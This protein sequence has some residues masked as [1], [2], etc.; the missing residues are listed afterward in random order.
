MVEQLQNKHQLTILSILSIVSVIGI[1]PFVVLR[2]LQD[3]YLGAILDF[4]LVLGILML[5][6]YA[7]RTGNPR[8]PCA[9]VAIFINVGVLGII[10]VNGIDSFLWVYPVCAVTFFLV[11]PY[12]ALFISLITGGVIINLPNIFDS[13]PLESYIMTSL[14]LALCAFVYASYGQ[15]QLSLLAMLNTTDP[16]TGAL[17]RRALDAD[18]AAALAR[19]ERN[20]TQHLLAFLDLDHFKKINDKYG[21]GVG[22]QVLKKLVTIT[23]AHIRQYDQLYRFG[24]EEFVLLIPEITPQQQQTFIDNLRVA[25]KQELKTADGKEVTVSF[26]VASWVKGTTVA[27]WLKRADDALY[28]AKANGR[29]CAVFSDE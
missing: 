17:N 2:Y 27:S 26:G 12:E 28:Q 1:T 7:R 19:A 25:I 4:T 18:M 6:F 13:I 5:M 15:K 24:G 8:L 21:H 11:K 22:D 20:N 3:N 9:I 23:K 14:I 16:L 29:D 10:V